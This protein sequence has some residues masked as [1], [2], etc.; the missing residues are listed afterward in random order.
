MALA[1]LNLKKNTI[2]IRV[3][4][5]PDTDTNTIQ[6]KVSVQYA[7]KIQLP[8]LVVTKVHARTKWYLPKPQMCYIL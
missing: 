2:C 5:L 3:I 6:P 1:N 7:D 4:F 8:T